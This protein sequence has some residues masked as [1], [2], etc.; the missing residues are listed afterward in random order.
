MLSNAEFTRREILRTTAAAGAFALAAGLPFTHAAGATARGSGRLKVGVIGCGGRGTGAAINI[1]EAGDDA[2]IYALGDLF[3]DRLRGCL[4]ELKSHDAAKGRLNVDDARLF[5]GFDACRKVLD[6]G[7]DLVILATPPGFRPHHLEAA[8]SAGKHVFMEKPV[9]V[10]PAGVRSVLA[11]ARAAQEKKLNIVTGTQRRHAA[12]Y[13]E[14]MKRIAG[15]ELGR[16]VSA[17]VYWNQGGLW[18]NDRQEAWTDT[19]WQLR[20][21]LYFT[22]LSGDHI[23]EQHVH[24]LDI[25]HWAMGDVPVRCS[26]QGGR[27]VR[28]GPEY[29]HVFD[30]FAVEYEY[31]DGRAV[32]SYCRQIDGCAS[33]VEEVIRGTEGQA[34]TAD[35]SGGRAVF[36]GKNAWKWTGKQENPYVS[37]HRALLAGV[38]GAGPYINEGERIAHSTLMAVMGRMAAYSGKVVTWKHALES[39]LNLMPKADLALGKMDPG[40]VAV[41]GKTPLI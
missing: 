4:S 27:Q 39:D 15:G 9:A 36:T 26:A 35:V 22:W 5:T 7:V 10:C 25:A 37:E 33:R 11:S 2:E 38:T 19:E 13:V 32:N 21:W 40:E 31:A 17:S 14:A 34:V 6:S 20:N 29:G 8:V 23:C 24:N 18:K 1:L 41:P 3:P 12:S 30:H 16:I 28:T